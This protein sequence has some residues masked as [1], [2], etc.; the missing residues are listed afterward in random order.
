MSDVPRAQVK[1]HSMAVAPSSVSQPVSQAIVPIARSILEA[2]SP[3][4]RH[5]YN[6]PP[7]PPLQ[8]NGGRP[9][10]NTFE[11][12]DLKE[13]K[14]KRGAVGKLKALIERFDRRWE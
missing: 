2:P 1:R 3:I 7:I 14:T 10:K 6:I 5:S 13:G 4:K 9:A 12:A 11:K 8:W